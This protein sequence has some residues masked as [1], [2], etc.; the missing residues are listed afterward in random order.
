[1]SFVALFLFVFFGTVLFELARSWTS[2]KQEWDKSTEREGRASAERV[3]Q[4]RKRVLCSE[5]PPKVADKRE[6]AFRG[7]KFYDSGQAA[8]EAIGFTMLGD[9]A[10]DQ[11]VWTRPGFRTFIRCG[12]SHDREAVCS[13]LDATPHLIGMST[14]EKCHFYFIGA[15]RRNLKGVSLRTEL[16]DGRFLITS[17]DIDIAKEELPPEVSK[18]TMPVRT[19][20]AE[21]L[22]RHRGRVVQAIAGTNATVVPIATVE[23]FG[24]SWVRHS[25]ITRAWREKIGYAMTQQEQR[26]FIDSSTVLE[27]TM[28]D[29]MLESMR[30]LEDNE[31]RRAS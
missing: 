5:E 4:N 16:S 26:D 3:L 14:F 12:I 18:D 23:Q 13:I 21:L 25:R 7:F 1:V 29:T 17:T 2:L 20:A 27:R 8:F 9:F 22:R 30:E 31:R 28:A 24:Q 6:F 11:A 15:H 19:S 10:L